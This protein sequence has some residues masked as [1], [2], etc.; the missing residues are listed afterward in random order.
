MDKPPTNKW[1]V[2]VGDAEPKGFRS[3]NKA[4]EFVR[5]HLPSGARAVVHSWERG[6]WGLYE[7]FDQQ[8]PDDGADA[9]DRRL[10]DN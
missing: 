1:R 7:E 2:K 10:A 8:P 5:E 4:Y 3:E 9:A 6:R